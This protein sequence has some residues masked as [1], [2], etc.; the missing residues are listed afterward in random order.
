MSLLAQDNPISFLSDTTEYAWPTDA[1]EYLSSTFGETRSAHLHSGI[2]IRTWGQEG[3]RVF[4]SRDGEVYRIGIG[5]QGYGYAIYLK[6]SDG[7]FTV[8]AHLNRF[9]PELQALADSIRLKDYSFELDHTPEYETI[10]YKKGDIIGYTGSTG[11]GPPHLHFEIR[12]NDFNAVNPLLTNLSRYVS[13]QIPPIFTQLGIEYLDTDNYRYKDFELFPATNVDN[14]FDF[15]EIEIEGPVG[16]S[17][18][19]HDKANRTPNSYAV[20]SLMMVHESDTLFH[21]VKNSFSFYH[22]GDMFLDRSYHI[23]SQTGRGF[24]RLYK[25]HGN[26]LPIYQKAVNEGVLHLDDGI[27]PIKIIAKDIYGNQSVAT[28]KL[29]ANRSEKKEPIKY[30]ASYPAPETVSNK[31]AYNWLETVLVPQESLIASAGPELVTPDYQ[32]V[33]FHYSGKHSVEKSLS[34]NTF[35]QLHTADQKLWIQ[36]PSGSL[37]DTLSVRM[38]VIQTLNQIDIELSPTEL[39]LGKSAKFNYILPDEF[40]ERTRLALFSVDP[41]KNREK[42]ISADN[43]SG[44]I[45]ARIDEITNLRIREDRTAPWVGWPEIAQNLAGMHIVRIPVKDGDT[46]IDYEKSS[47]SINDEQGI[48]EYDPEENH[49]IY[50][51]PDFEPKSINSV[52]Y[53]IYDG[54]GNLTSRTVEIY[55]NP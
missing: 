22:S 38:E 7:S 33:K 11:V 39:P 14:G 6:H 53:Q 24:Q 28:V 16:L 44:L 42:H 1:T 17:I 35:D 51:N 23:L 49:L 52:D 12:D 15:G 32:N 5:P 25:V 29:N 50:Y 19:V 48:A 20:Y 31:T 27:Y 13:D 46:G 45:R 4:A 37:Y 40:K 3:Y 2:D 21:S 9:E 10:D 26:R 43:S 30:V 8:Y 47:I 36:F 55:Y 54:V 18:N 34:P 41:F